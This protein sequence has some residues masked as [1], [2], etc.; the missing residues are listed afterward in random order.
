MVST[1]APSQLWRAAARRIGV[2]NPSRSRVLEFLRYA[3][4]GVLTAGIYFVT[5][6]GAAEMLAATMLVATAAGFVG[7]VPVNFM[8]HRLWSF[9]SRRRY[10]EALPRYAVALGCAFLVNW[11]I[12]EVSIAWLSLHYLLAT[13][14]ATPWLVLTNYLVFRFWVFSDVHPQKATAGGADPVASDEA[15]KTARPRRKP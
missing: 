13:A 7:A 11:A 1:D 4:T 3:T 15:I 12:V 10:R 9:G 5:V 8:V 6:Y 14:V 2:Q